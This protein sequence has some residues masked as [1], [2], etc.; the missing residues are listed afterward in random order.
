[1]ITARR[2]IAPD[3]IRESVSKFVDDEGAVLRALQTI[4]EVFGYVPDAGLD[5]VAEI[6]NVSRADVYGVFTFY[7]DFRSTPPAPNVLKLCIAEACQANGSE[8]LAEAFEIEMGLDVHAKTRLADVEIEPVYCLGNC[9]LGPAA[10]VNGQLIGRV[11]VAKI[12]DI[13]GSGR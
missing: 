2:E 7:S 12:Q 13:L 8:A 10:L 3:E 4:Q 6:C 11:S 1:V 5:V 9:A